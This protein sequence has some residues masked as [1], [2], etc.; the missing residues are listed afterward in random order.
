METQAK[1]EINRLCDK[2]Y[3][4]EMK[5]P[6]KRQVEESHAN[7]FVG[8]LEI[9]FSFQVFFQFEILPNDVICSLL[10]GKPSFLN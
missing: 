6:S 9:Q 3:F 4:M 2:L 1:T 10:S 5:S 7:T 8:L